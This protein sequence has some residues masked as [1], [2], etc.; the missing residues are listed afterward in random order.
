MPLMPT[1]PWSRSAS[2]RERRDR[3]DDGPAGGVAD[4]VAGHPDP[5]GLGVLVVHAG[6]A[7]VRGG[8]HHDLAVVRRVGQRLLVAGHAGRE[9]RLA[10]GL[11]RGAVGVAAEGAAVL[12]DEHCLVTGREQAR[13]P[14]LLL[15]LTGRIVKGCRSRPTISAARSDYC[16]AMDDTGRVLS[17]AD[18]LAREFLAGL[19]DAAGVAAGDLRGDAGGLRR[20]AAGV[21]GRPCRG[22]GGAGPDRRRGTGRDG[23]PAV[24]RLRDRGLHAGGARRRRA[25]LRL[26][27]ERRP[28]LADARRGRRRG[29]RRPL[30]G[31][32]RSGCP[33]ARP[34]AS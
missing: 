23:R 13:V 8:H 31:R 24:L 17:R 4:D 34:S 15:R 2:S 16:H 21:G 27:P 25:D 9:D 5:R 6:V 19:G 11:A 30:G 7:D 32:G 12:E 20:A 33:S 10:E 28:Q 26:G 18:E 3:H 29:R 22:G 1:T 14:D